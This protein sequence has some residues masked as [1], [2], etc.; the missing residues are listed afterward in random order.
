M[1]TTAVSQFISGDAGWTNKKGSRRQNLKN[2]ILDSSPH[3]G[4]SR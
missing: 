4:S 1:V 2:E 3:P